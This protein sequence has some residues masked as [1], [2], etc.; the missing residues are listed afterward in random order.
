[1]G[2]NV[3]WIALVTVLVLTATACGDADE[4]GV[5]QNQPTTTAQRG[6]EGPDVKIVS[7]ADGT[8]VKGNVV[9]LDFD[10]EGLTIVKADG[11]KSGRSGHLHVFVDKE[12][13][14]SGQ[15]IPV[16]AGIVHTTDDPVRVPGLKV[17]RHTL[18]VVLGDGTHTRIG[19]VS[20]KV[21]VNVEGP[22]VD[23]SAPPTA[24][25]NQP[26]AIAAT[27]EGV[28][29][30]P[31]NGDTSGRTGHLHVFV[32]KPPTPAGQPIPLGDPAILH[33][34]TAPVTVPPLPPG[35]HTFWVVVGNGAHVPLDPPVM[36]SLTV[37]VQ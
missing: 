13:V 18:T 25:A 36:D 10:V 16:E 31:A 30:S 34:A 21:T 27:V 17:G 32:D 35:P 19:E 1:M 28:Q 24:P 11:D 23:A 4:E 37:T 20:D 8:A 2:R 22:A 6:E 5:A 3:R 26:L 12:P 14:A 33:S 9:T 29:L 7:P 15:V